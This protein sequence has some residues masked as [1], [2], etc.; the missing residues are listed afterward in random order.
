[1]LL[2]DPAPRAQ[3]APEDGDPEL[4]HHAGP[5]DVDR[6]SVERLWLHEA[7]E[8]AGSAAPAVDRRGARIGQRV[9]WI[10]GPSQGAPRNPGGAS[11]ATRVRGFA[12]LKEKSNLTLRGL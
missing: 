10:Q 8:A 9:F 3:V 1:M 11:G 7:P 2:L 12:S 5:E 4:L 6:D